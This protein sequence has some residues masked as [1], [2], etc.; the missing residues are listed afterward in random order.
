MINTWLPI[1]PQLPHIVL[2]HGAFNDGSVWLP[3]IERLHAQG[4]GVTAVQNPLSSLADDV[5]ATE[6]VVNRYDNV[7]LVGHS[8]AGAVI[9]EAGNLPQVKALV[10]ISALIPD[11]RSSVADTMTRLNAP[12]DGLQPDEQG[13]MWLDDPVAYRAFMGADIPQ[14][15]I[16]R[17][18][19]VSQPIH[20]SAFM[21]PVGTP[22][23][24]TKPSYYLLTQNDQALPL[25]VQE[26]FAQK[27]GATTRSIP[28]SHLPLVSRPDDV[29]ALIVQASQETAAK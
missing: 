16:N 12:M 18:A 25:A 29:A 17:L 7:I 19:A 4:Y 22:A 26:Q 10:Y 28:G 20:V 6:R 15:T 23:W 9:G 21:A 27:I 5:Q 14:E 8:W 3:V 2:V 24:K 1:P 13:W 11:E